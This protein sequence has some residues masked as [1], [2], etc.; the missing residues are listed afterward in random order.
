MF[1]AFVAFNI[2]YPTV[3]QQRRAMGTSKRPGTMCP[4]RVARGVRYFHF[5]S[6][7]F[8]ERLTCSNFV[9]AH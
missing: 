6:S 8:I 7:F 3:V 9:S 1:H 4:E 5:P 2:C